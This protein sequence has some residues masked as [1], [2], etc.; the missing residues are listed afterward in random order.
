MGA[1]EGGFDIDGA[2]RGELAGDAEHFQFGLDIEAIAG[3]DFDGGDAFSQYGVESLQCGF[4]KLGFRGFAGGAHGGHD[5]AAC[6]GNIRISHAI[7]THFKFMGAIAAIDQM[8]VAIDEAGGEQLAAAIM[9][10][11]CRRRHIGRADPLDHSVLSQYTAILDQAIAVD[12]GSDSNICEEHGFI[13]L[14]KVVYTV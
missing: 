7:E 14:Y 12:H 6:L 10:G 1:E 5:A 8:G 13:H 9:D 3:F 11:F 4:Q 2:K